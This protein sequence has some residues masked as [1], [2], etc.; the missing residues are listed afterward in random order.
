MPEHS[1]VPAVIARPDAKRPPACRWQAGRGRAEAISG[2]WRLLRS[3]KAVA[4]NDS[5]SLGRARS[6]ALGSDWQSV[7]EEK[8]H[9]RDSGLLRSGVPNMSDLFGNEAG[10]QRKTS[11]NEGRDGPI[12]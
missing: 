10:E 12:V 11:K 7:S 3:Q 1:H 2:K 6:A 8:T 5:E 9:D 4:R